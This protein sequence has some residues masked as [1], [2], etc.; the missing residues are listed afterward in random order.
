MSIGTTTNIHGR[1]DTGGASIRAE[2]I[3]GELGAFPAF[4]TP[5]KVSESAEH[6]TSTFPT[7]AQAKQIHGALDEYLKSKGLI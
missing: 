7:D 3:D 4:V 6:G 2:I 5:Q 1:D